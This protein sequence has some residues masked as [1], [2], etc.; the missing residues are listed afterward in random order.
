VI[1]FDEFTDEY[2]NRIDELN[3][4]KL[5]IRELK[6]EL[7]E[8]DLENYSLRNSNTFLFII[9]GGVIVSTSKKLSDSSIFT[10]DK[11]STID[12]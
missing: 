11:D 12:D 4:A 5:I 3:D 10:D 6:V 2:N 9:E 1:E 7:R 8:R